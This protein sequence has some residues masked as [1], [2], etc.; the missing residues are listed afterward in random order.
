MHNHKH[1][2]CDH[3]HLEFCKHCNYVFCHD[4]DMTWNQANAWAWRTYPQLSNSYTVGGTTTAGFAGSSVTMDC[5][6]HALK[7][8]NEQEDNFR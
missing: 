7:S 5:K 3:T 2:R 4:C 8:G 1:N 6:H